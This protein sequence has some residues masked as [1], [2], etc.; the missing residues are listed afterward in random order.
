MS[1]IVTRIFQK[2]PT[3]KPTGNNTYVAV[4]LIKNKADVSDPLFVNTTLVV[5]RV[6]FRD[7]HQTLTIC[8][9]SP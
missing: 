8:Q 2:A 1:P 9:S 5:F 7:N 3:K 6:H 4:S